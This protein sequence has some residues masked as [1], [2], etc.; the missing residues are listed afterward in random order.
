VFNFT[1]A[2]QPYGQTAPVVPSLVIDLE[3]PVVLNQQIEPKV[4][5]AFVFLFDL[6]S[7]A[8]LQGPAAAQL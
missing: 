7:T 3:V 8:T 5:A 2:N 1:K 6:S 4:F